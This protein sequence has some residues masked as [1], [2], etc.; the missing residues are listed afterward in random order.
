MHYKKYFF[1]FFIPFIFCVIALVVML[2]WNAILPDLLPV[3]SINYWQALGLLI[4]CRILSG[5]MGG[6]A[7]QKPFGRFSQHKRDKWMNM[8]EEEKLKVKEEWRK[9][10]G[11]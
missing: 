10:W 5:S 3:R 2:L 7:Y 9:R 4:L 11:R 1:W 8:S 6:G